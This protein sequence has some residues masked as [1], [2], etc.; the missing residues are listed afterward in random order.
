MP[1]EAEY[2]RARCILEL[3]VAKHPF[4]CGDIDEIRGWIQET[5][6]E[7]GEGDLNEDLFT[8]AYEEMGVA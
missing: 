2:W 4:S 7:L 8:I 5:I 1:T 3:T 6:K